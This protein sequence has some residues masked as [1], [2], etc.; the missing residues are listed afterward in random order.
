MAQLVLAARSLNRPEDEVLSVLADDAHPGTKVVEDP[1]V[2]DSRPLPKFRIV[3]VANVPVAAFHALGLLL[4]D[5]N[6]DKNIKRRRVLNLTVAQNTILNTERQTDLTL[7]EV[8]SK[9]HPNA[10]P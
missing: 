3:R 2:W 9:S 8:V 6:P 10:T 7:G 4:P 5:K 1:N